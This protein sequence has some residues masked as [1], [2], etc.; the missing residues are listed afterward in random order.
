L[1]WNGKTKKLLWLSYEEPVVILKEDGGIVLE[2]DRGRL[3]WT[4]RED[5]DP[6]EIKQTPERLQVLEVVEELSGEDGVSLN[7][8]ARKLD[9]SPQA[10]K[11]LLDKLIREGL[12]MKIGR[13]KYK[14]I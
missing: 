11:Y 5:L 14:P 3:T 8:V 4:V 7:M 13:G 6:D 2:G 12:V 9:K 1:Y 10:T